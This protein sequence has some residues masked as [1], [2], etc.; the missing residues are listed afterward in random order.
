MT[1]D[2]NRPLSPFTLLLFFLMLA[3][4]VGAMLLTGLVEL[5]HRV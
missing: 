4:I 3:I 2:R 5:S 1:D